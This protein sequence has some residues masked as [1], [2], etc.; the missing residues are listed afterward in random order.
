[1]RKVVFAQQEDES[2]GYYFSEALLSKMK[3]TAP[4][5]RDASTTY[6]LNF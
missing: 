4:A 6:S 2:A 3:P 1:M 5:I